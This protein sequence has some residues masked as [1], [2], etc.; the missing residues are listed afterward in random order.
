V[1]A[2]AHITVMRRVCSNKGTHLAAYKLCHYGHT[3]VTGVM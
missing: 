2:L 1:P 3:D